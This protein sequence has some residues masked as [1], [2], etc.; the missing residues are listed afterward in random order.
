MISVGSLINVSPLNKLTQLSRTT[1]LSL[2]RNAPWK[3]VF[4]CRSVYIDELC[5]VFHFVYDIDDIKRPCQGH[6]TLTLGHRE[7]LWIHGAFLLRQSVSTMSLVTWKAKPNHILEWN[8]K[9]LFNFQI[10]L[11]CNPGR[12]Y[13]AYPLHFFSRMC[14]L[15]GFRSFTNHTANESWSKLSVLSISP[16]EGTAFTVDSE[17]KSSDALPSMCSWILLHSQSNVDVS[18]SSGYHFRHNTKTTKQLK[19]RTY[20]WCYN[21]KNQTSLSRFASLFY[22]QAIYQNSAW[23]LPSLATWS[24]KCQTDFW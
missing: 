15:A 18:T 1:T 24:K 14:L 10:T 4:F 17:D 22:N 19:D 9:S 3:V 13:S 8:R 21:T 16:L 23:L 6:L 2:K 12:G 7:N 20:T 11:W 5:C